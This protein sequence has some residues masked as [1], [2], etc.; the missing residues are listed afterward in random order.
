MLPFER[1]YRESC[2]A[3][4]DQQF[5]ATVFSSYAGFNL[6]YALIFIPG[7]GIMAAYTDAQT[8]EL[9]PQFPQAL[10][11][12]VWAWLIVSVIFT[13][14]ATRSSWVLLILLVFV[15]LTLVF[16]AAGNMA[17]VPQ[18][19]TAAS[20]TGFI[21]SFLACKSLLSFFFPFS[22]IHNLLLLRSFLER[23]K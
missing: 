7:S 21:A 14:A 17:D 16:L 13:V 5:G 3:D 9:S 18:L 23:D 4:N 11:M 15:D 20:A 10:A 8:G 22:L 12:F 1:K 19:Q 6:A 2:S